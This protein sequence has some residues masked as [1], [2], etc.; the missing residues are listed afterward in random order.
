MMVNLKVKK[1][2]EAAILPEYAHEGDAGLDL[3]SIEE[4]IIKAGESALIRTG[5]QMEL[6]RD[7]EAQVRPRSGLALKH[8]ITVLNTPGTIDEGYRGEVKIILINH[9][10]EDFKV[11]KSMK[12]AQMVI[13]PVLRVKVEEVE[14]LSDTD[15]GQGGFGSSGLKK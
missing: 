2:D 3:F 15:R 8:S 6:P 12:I 13:K 4:K 1:I 10:K 9:G 11:E 5:I 14:E 7:T